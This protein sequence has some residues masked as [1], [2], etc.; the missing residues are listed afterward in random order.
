MKHAVD[1]LT[2]EFLRYSCAS[3]TAV[4]SGEGEASLIRFL[5]EGI[6]RLRARLACIAALNTAIPSVCGKA[7]GALSP[8]GNRNRNVV[9]LTL[10]TSWCRTGLA[11]WA[12]GERFA[13]GFLKIRFLESCALAAFWIAALGFPGYAIAA[14]ELLSIDE[15]AVI[16]YDAPSL[17]AGKVYVASRHLPVEA[18]V[19]VEGW[20]K[21][22]DSTGSLAWVEEKALS[23]KRYVI[24]TAPLAEAYQAAN[25]NSPLVFQA[26]QDVI[27]E[28]VEP[29]TAG[30]ARVRHRDGQSG[31]VRTNQ[32][33]GS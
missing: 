27:L 26:Q 13:Q 16:M 20:V 9:F 10:L 25:E 23:E 29:G 17:K 22:R 2:G 11:R 19:K 31:Y 4:A 1:A 15:N 32:V 12:P 33:W 30:W 18:V 7:S 28:L 3:D 24:V 8:P 14:F 6:R 21:V 5:A